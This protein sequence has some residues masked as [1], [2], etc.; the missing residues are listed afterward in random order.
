MD[1]AD[2]SQLIVLYVVWKSHGPVAVRGRISV[3]LSLDGDSHSQPT[4]PIRKTA[5]SSQHWKDW[6]DGSPNN[7][8]LTSPHTHHTL[9]LLREPSSAS[10]RHD[11]SQRIHAYNTTVNA[12]IAQNT[13]CSIPFPSTVHH[14]SRSC[15][16]RMP[17]TTD[18]LQLP[19]RVAT[20]F[21]RST[22]P[23]HPSPSH[24]TRYIPRMSLF[25]E[26]MRDEVYQIWSLWT[27]SDL[28]MSP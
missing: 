26:V 9:P 21:K 28:F 25:R 19:P 4:G 11:E 12:E 3:H 14:T 1:L 22:S 2:I 17:T 6:S 5:H 13:N 24:F 10:I 15:T 18:G 20:P 23:E 27:C 16:V 8:F 7:C